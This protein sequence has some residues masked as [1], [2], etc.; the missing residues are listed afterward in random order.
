HPRSIAAPDNLAKQNRFG[1]L[2]LDKHS[3]A[4]AVDRMKNLDGKARRSS[5]RA[6]TKDHEFPAFTQP[7]LDVSDHDQKKPARWL[8]P[9]EAAVLEEVRSLTVFCDRRRIDY[10]FFGGLAT[11]AFLGFAH[12]PLHDVDVMLDESGVAAV[13]DF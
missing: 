10:A 4:R 7:E 11:S 1:D 12:R 2:P 8:R 6:V 13:E 9:K 3:V 5:Q